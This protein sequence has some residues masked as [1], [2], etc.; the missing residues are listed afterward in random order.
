MPHYLGDHCDKEKVIFT[1][2]SLALKIFTWSGMSLH[3]HFIGQTINKAIIYLK[4]DIKMDNTHDYHAK[5]EE[6]F[7]LKQMQFSRNR[8]IVLVD[9]VGLGIFFFF[10]IF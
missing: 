1:K 2:T 4:G 3:L 8:T 7:A 5:K 10:F 9:Q 6:V